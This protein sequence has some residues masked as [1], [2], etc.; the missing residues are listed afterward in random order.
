[1]DAYATHIEPLVKAA[2]ETPG[3]ILELGC[4]DYSTPILA[5]ICRDRGSKLTVHA[6]DPDWANR[7][8]EIADIH[9]VDWA[10]YKLEGQYGLIFLDN[11]E[12]S[13]G[14]MA[15]LALLKPHAKVIVMHDASQAKDTTPWDT[16]T[17]IFSNVEMY[18]KHVPHTAVFTC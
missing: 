6:S 10:N 11:E 7:Y 2:L 3:D 13:P 16:L 9:I 5:A 17:S 1:M 12:H 15:K 18:T 14:R 4:G 8:R